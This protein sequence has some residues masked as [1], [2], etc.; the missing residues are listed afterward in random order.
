MNK[1]MYL[2][3][4][5]I[6]Y[7]K[8][9]FNELKN[10]K[11]IVMV[12]ILTSLRIIAGLFFIPITDN[13]RIYFTF[14]FV[15]LIGFLYGPLSGIV[16]GIISDLVTFMIFPTGAFFIGYMIS[17]ALSGFIFGLFLYK[18]RITFSKIFFSKFIINIF[19]NALLGSLWWIIL[20]KNFTYEFYLFTMFPKLIKNI[21]MLPLEIILIYYVF[22][23]IIPI[24]NNDNMITKKYDMI[25]NYKKGFHTED[26]AAIFAMIAIILGV[27]SFVFIAFFS[28]N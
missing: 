28:F 7:W 1:T 24:V 22:R 11:S 26:L 23:F 16:S 12:S 8:T 21:I 25:N 17:A 19:I 5:S 27:L 18:T 4:F 20:V 10:V 14:V 3:Q 13:N 6:N 2:S 9:A 15:L